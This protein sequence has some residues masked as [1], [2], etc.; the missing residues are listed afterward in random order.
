MTPRYVFLG[1]G[2][3]IGR[4]GL[5]YL[6]ELFLEELPELPPD[7]WWEAEE[8]LRTGIGGDGGGRSDCTAAW[9]RNRFDGTRLTPATCVMIEGGLHH[10]LGHARKRFW[11]L[12]SL[13]G[14]FLDRAGDR[15]EDHGFEF[16]ALHCF[17]KVKFLLSNLLDRAG[18][19]GV[20][21]LALLYFQLRSEV[22]GDFLC[23]LNGRKGDETLSH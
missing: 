17:L 19:Y 21:L 23:L 12:R 9:E 1:E 2:R 10:F 22:V 5:R 7:I 14:N 11:N 6:I 3:R 8:I 18:N 4:L 15:V 16:V 13:L 20:S